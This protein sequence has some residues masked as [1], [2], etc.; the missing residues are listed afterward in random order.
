VNLDQVREAAERIRGVARRTRVV[1][2]DLAGGRLFCKAEHEQVTG[3]FKIRGAY[4]CGV[5]VA[6]RGRGFV[7]ISSGNHAQAVAKTA[8]LLDTSALIAMPEDSAPV[9]IA[10]TAA[11]GAEIVTFDRFARDRDDVLRE[12]LASSNRTF[13]P[14]Y[15]HPHVIAGQG[16]VALELVEDAGPLDVL[17][18]PVSG[19]G[20]IAGCGIAAKAL[21]PHVKLVGVEPAAA[22]DTARSLREGERVTI[23]APVTIA[24]GLRVQTPGEI[25]FEINR[26]Q[27]DEVVVVTDDEI[28]QAMAALQDATGAVVEPSG[29]VGVAAVLAGRIDVRDQRAGVVLSGG[30][31]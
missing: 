28:R 16:T 30:N 12:L 29:A 11:L 13:I 2:I 17:I 25:T 7:A 22:D 4:N 24:D 6:N 15:D 14:P 1:E 23:P 9:K 3:S 5:Q 21:H 19:G 20:L 10:A 26:R 8:Q 18:V 31:V 27:I